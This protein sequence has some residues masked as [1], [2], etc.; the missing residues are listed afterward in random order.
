[1]NAE[2]VVKLFNM[3][4]FIISEIIYFVTLFFALVFGISVVGYIC[5]IMAFNTWKK[6]NF[7]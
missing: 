3:K 7:K 4:P 1:M 6:K 2:N 5:G